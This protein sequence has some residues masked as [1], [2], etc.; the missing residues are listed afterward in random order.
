MLQDAE[1]LLVKRKAFFLAQKGRIVTFGIT[2]DS[3]KTGFSYINQDKA[4][5]NDCVNVDRFVEK[6]NAQATLAMLSE[7][8]IHGTAACSYFVHLSLSK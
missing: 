7:G 5:G 8:A 4:R 3:P 1:Y 2:P 6:P